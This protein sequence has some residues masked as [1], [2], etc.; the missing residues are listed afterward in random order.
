VLLTKSA[1]NADTGSWATGAT[2]D[3][4]AKFPPPGAADEREHERGARSRHGRLA[5]RALDDGARCRRRR[6]SSAAA[7]SAEV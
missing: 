5:A 7:G 1:M 6:P 3:L 4:A 2:A